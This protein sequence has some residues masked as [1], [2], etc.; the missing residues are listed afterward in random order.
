MNRTFLKLINKTCSFINY[1]VPSGNGRPDLDDRKGI[2]G[3]EVRSSTTRGPQTGER[4]N[5]GA[6]DLSLIS[7]YK[8][9]E[10]LEKENVKKLK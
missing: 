4:G 2:C 9:G 6:S 8:L 10:T 7:F 3:W 5:Q 1:Q